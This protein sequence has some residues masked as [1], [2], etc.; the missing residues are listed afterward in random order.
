M[1]IAEYIADQ[2]VN[3]NVKQTAMATFSSVVSMIS[4]YVMTSALARFSVD[5]LYDM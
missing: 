5:R 3:V 2:L 1:T 4:V